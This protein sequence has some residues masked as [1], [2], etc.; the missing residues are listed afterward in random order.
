MFCNRC[1]RY[2]ADGTQQCPNCGQFL[3]QPYYPPPQPQIQLQPD[4]SVNS[5]MAEAILVTLFCCMPAG[6][7]AIAYASQVS[8]LVAAGKYNAAKSTSK[9]AL[10]WVLGGLIA[11]LAWPVFFFLFIIIAANS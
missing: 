2:L 4:I 11:G 7:I 9:T 10:Y 1:G 8:N 6:I 5:H 3:Q